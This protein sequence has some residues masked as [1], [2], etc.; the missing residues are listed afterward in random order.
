M[1]NASRCVFVFAAAGLAA[2]ASAQITPIGPFSGTMNEAPTTNFGFA[3][4]VPGRVFSNAADLCTFDANGAPATGIHAT[5]GWSFGCVIFPHSG[6]HFYGSASGIPEFNFDA[7]IMRFGGYFGANHDTIVAGGGTLTF[8]DQGNNPIGSPLQMTLPSCGSW[9]WRG[10]ESTVP[11]K[12]IKIAS[13]A[14]GGGF[15]MMDDL[16]ADPSGGGGGGCYANCDSSTIVPFLNVLDFSCFLNKFA[17]G[18]T[19][20]NCDNSTIAPALNVLD[21]SCFLNKFAAGCSA[22]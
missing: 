11:I 22:P 4:C 20:A 5:I 1:P 16:T 21:F 13:S 12:R 10:W 8:Y 18:H 3:Q 19:Y 17:A 9:E 14:F 15:I 7:P 2:S 6:T